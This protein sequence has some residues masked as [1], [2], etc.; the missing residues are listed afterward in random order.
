L[1][2][3]AVSKMMVTLLFVGML[4]LSFN[5]QVMLAPASTTTIF[6]D[7]FESYAVGTFPSAGG[8]ELWTNGAG[9]AY[10]VIVDSFS[11]SP[12]KSLQLRGKPRWVAT[13]SKRYTA[14]SIQVGFEVY[15]RINE[16]EGMDGS[17]ARVA[18]SVRPDPL[19]IR[20]YSTVHFGYYDEHASIVLSG[21][22]ELQS[23]VA[24]EWYKVKQII[25]KSSDTCS[26]W[27]NDVLKA[28]NVDLDTNDAPDDIFHYNDTEAL[29]LCSSYANINAYFDD[30][31]IFQ[32]PP[33]QPVASFTWTPENPEPDELVTFD[34]SASYDPDDTIVD[35]VWDLGD[36]TN[37]I[38][39]IV[40]HAYSEPG[41]YIVT[42]TVWDAA[43]NN[44][45]AVAEITVGRA[46]EGYEDFM[47]YTEVDPNDHIDIPSATHIDHASWLDEDAYV[48][49][50]KGAD[51]FTDFTHLVDIRSSFTG[52]TYW[53]STWMLTN[54]VDDF[55]GLRDSGKDFL[56]I[57]L[58]HSGAGEK[59]ITLRECDSGIL[60]TDLYYCSANTWYYLTI[61]KEGTSLT[62][63]IYEDSSRTSLLDTLSL[64]LHHDYS[65]RYI[66]ACNTNDESLP[67]KHGD[68]DIENLYLGEPVHV[69]YPSIMVVPAITEDP[70]LTPGKNF[71]I[72]IKTDYNGTD[73]Q[74]YQF[75]LSYNPN[76]LHG[77]EVTNGDLITTDE[78][79]SATFM[80]GTFDNTEGTLSLTGAF[81]FFIVK[82]API[83]SGPGI[84]ANVTFTVVGYGTSDITI[85]PETVLFGYTEGGYGEPYHI[86]DA[87]TM[88]DHIQH[89]YFDNTE[90]PPPPP[91][92][93]VISLDPLESTV[94]LGDSFTIDVTVVD[95][96]DLGCW[97]FSLSYNTTILDAISVSP[98]PDT[99]NNT[100]WVPVDAEG[101]FHPDGPPAVDDTMGRVMVGALIPVPQGQGLT[102]SFTLLTINF[103]AT[104]A[105]ECALDLYDTVLGDSM[106]NAISHTTLDGSVTVHSHMPVISLNPTESTVQFGDSF[107]IDVNVTDVTD[108]GAWEFKLD[109]DPTI[110]DAVEVIYEGRITKNNIYW[111][112][113][114]AEGVFHPDGPPTIDDTIGRVW[115]GALFPIGEEFTGSGILLTINFTAIAPGNC[116]LHLYDTVLGDSMAAPISHRTL[117]GSVTVDPGAEV[118]GVVVTDVVQWFKDPPVTDAAYSTWPIN[119][120]VTVE[121]VG[122]MTVNC[123]VTVYYDSIEIATQTVTDLIS[124]EIRTLTLVGDITG[125]DP[126][127]SAGVY[128]TLKANATTIG[129]PDFNLA[130]N[131][132]VYGQV[133]IRRWGDVDGS[134]T[135]TILDLKKCK[136]AYSG[137]IDEPF[138]DLDGDCDPDI[139]DIKLISLI[140]SGYLP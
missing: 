8:W 121:N 13:A 72:S 92:R 136:L 35:Y 79:P 24:G 114:D 115:V 60:R 42:L 68:V 25:D 108:L 57:T 96:T 41:S 125:L 62:C 138:A 22:G 124:A 126:G 73:I 84:L 63:E 59:K 37:A 82:P 14:E 140:Y 3:K 27:I 85:G 50:D 130:D 44:D 134:D 17:I 117:D 95:V 137:I 139:L 89:G 70:T 67:V 113:V 86:I 39:M 11:V 94:Q 47:T 75:T 66:F 64:T 36:G 32:R 83:T 15:V 48:Y 112:P 49:T 87:E 26:V 100:D 6:E 131:E 21:Y 88:P 105:G 98:T 69:E 51:H 23:F 107:T 109:Y 30:V 122:S 4:T 31:K 19:H 71:T 90:P 133:K 34:A 28:S 45:T 2:R 38:G 53:T 101:V 80:P 135:I 20:F 123:T 74:A 12:S 120:N 118:Y 91:P 1:E 46:Q 102:G 78:H 77:V 81:F 7:D 56:S 10:Q 111:M 43:G 52:A 97:A 29:T 58:T 5:N 65:F 106:G 103:T 18:F 9:T 93:P 132:F 40:T 33:T 61:E 54:D 128:Y 99:A 104:E 76:V 16:L 127:H 119:L 110:L 55:S 129:F 116:T